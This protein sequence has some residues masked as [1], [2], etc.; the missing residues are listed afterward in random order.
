LAD[1]I[2]AALGPVTGPRLF[3]ALAILWS[4]AARTRLH[5]LCREGLVTGDELHYLTHLLA[6]YRLDGLAIGVFVATLRRPSG[7][8]WLTIAMLAALAALAALM[9]L[10]RPE[11]LELHRF[12]LVAVIFGILVHGSTG[13]TLWSKCTI[14]GMRFIADLS[15]S[16]YLMH[17]F[18]ERLVEMYIPV[19]Q[20]WLRVL[21]FVPTTLA[22]SLGLRHLVELPFLR[23]RDATGP[24]LRPSRGAASISCVAEVSPHG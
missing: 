5:W 2:V 17:P 8:R 6:H 18:A 3:A 9:Y 24:A 20:M 7:S 23:W 14:P 21:V 15:Y 19:S 1:A 16:L 4:V 22:L 12:G 11:L 10:P 13:N